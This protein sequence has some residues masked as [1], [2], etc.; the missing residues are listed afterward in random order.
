VTTTHELARLLLAGPD[1][2]VVVDGYE[3]GYSDP[4]VHGAVV[5]L[6]EGGSHDGD[7]GDD[8]GMCD[9]GDSPPV[10]QPGG[11]AAVLISRNDYDRCGL[12]SESYADALAAVERAKDA[13]YTEALR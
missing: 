10:P 3:G 8:W 12:A 9:E 6:G 13:H 7:H 4:R 11:V 5:R 1:V 2:R